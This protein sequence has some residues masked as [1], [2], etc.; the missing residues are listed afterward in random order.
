MKSSSEEARRRLVLAWVADQWPLQLIIV[1]N[2][3]TEL[4]Q[5]TDRQE[6]L[7]LSNMLHL[8]LYHI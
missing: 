8:V 5:L 2:N 6:C 7:K 4:K 3:V 1:W